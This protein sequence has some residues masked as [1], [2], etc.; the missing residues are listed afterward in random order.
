MLDNSTNHL[1]VCYKA[2]KWDLAAKNLNE[3]HVNGKEGGSG[4]NTSYIVIP[5]A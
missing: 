4:L 1:G 2:S 3:N 5:N